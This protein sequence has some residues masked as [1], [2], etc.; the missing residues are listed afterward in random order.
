MLRSN[1]DITDDIEFDS[2][3]RYVGRLSSIDV[4]SYIGIDFR[5]G[6]KPMP[7]LE[8]SLVGQN[9]FSRSHAEFMPDF[10]LSLPVE[11]QR[12]FFYLLVSYRF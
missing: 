3:I 7:D 12:S 10:D 9:L 6:W 5:L 1:L 4:D 8:F 11:V 2:G